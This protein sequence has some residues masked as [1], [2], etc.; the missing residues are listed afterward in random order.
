MKLTDVCVRVHV[1]LVRGDEG[2]VAKSELAVIGGR[3]Q[4]RNEAYKG[5]LWTGQ[6]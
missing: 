2:G 3:R 4:W 6:P 1:T 5:W